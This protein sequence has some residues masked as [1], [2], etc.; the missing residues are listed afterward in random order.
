M[1]LR[2]IPGYPG[3][4][5][6]SAGTIIGKKGKEIGCFKAKYVLIGLGFGKPAVSRGKLILLAFHGPKPF[7][8]AEVEHLNR[9]KHDD[10]PENLKWE[11]RFNQMWNRDVKVDSAT[12]VKGLQW[13]NPSGRSING[14]WRCTVTRFGK[15]YCAHF[16]PDKRDEA[17]EWLN[18]KRAEL[19]PDPVV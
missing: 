13:V 8:E 9:N 12:Q 17:V 6:T 15:D 16:P 1:E 3:L 4:T 18:L 5:A 7:P 14:R 10:R 11:N 2:E 19:L